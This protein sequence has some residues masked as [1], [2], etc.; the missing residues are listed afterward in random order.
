MSLA[1]ALLADFSDEEERSPSPA[2]E[3][4]S[5]S[6][7]APPDLSFP[8]SGTNKRP[9]S[10]MDLDTVGE[11][12]GINKG[13]EGDG[14]EGEGDG[15]GLTLEDGTSA[16]GYVPEGGVKPA[17]EL[18]VEDVERTDMMGFEDV[19][20]V[21]KLAGSRKLQ[22][23]IK[24]IAR[25]T[26]SPTDM[27]T[28]SGPLEE[29]PEY[30][31]VV[32][33]NNMSVEVDNEI[34]IVHKFIRD[35]YAPRFPE[36]EQLIA[37]PW[38]YIAA[39][40]AIGQNEDVTKVDFSKTLLPAT[41]LSITLTATTSRG[42]MLSGAEYET[43]QRAI[44][45]AQDLR[46]AREKIFNFVESR[47]AAVA[48]N[49][50]ILVGTGIAAKLLGLAGGLAAISRQPS[51]NVMLFGAMKKNLATS[52]LSAASQQR[53]TG[54]IFQSA[55]V[56]S[57]QPE[58]RRRAQR[59]VAAKVV[60]A[61]RIDA[62]KGSRDGSFGKTTLAQLQKKIE[63]MA[64]PP[65]NKLI[66]ALPIPQETNRKKRGG[67]RARKQKEAYAQTELRKLQNRMEF[68][69]AEEEIGVDD[70]TVGLGMIGSAGKV[71]G[72][73]ADS[74]SKAKLSRANKL[75][76][77]LLGRSQAS[78][79]AASGMSTSLSFTPVQ[80]L[81]IVTPSLSAAQRVKAAN[82]RWFAGGTFTHVKKD[83]SNL[84]GQ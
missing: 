62:G 19:G 73:M 32:T 22:D 64:E 3:Q 61:A 7:A 74:R 56:Q 35:H 65:P 49:L 25:F 29:N 28:A 31:L 10:A 76:T 51:C 84:P 46:D 52:H 66:K 41:M 1:D 13:G 63:K 78:N 83:Q 6:S 55:I 24:D 48:P 57:A 50:S 23:V 72:E 70:E 69:K 59:A 8:G 81:E 12:D 36:L 44:T 47:M 16:V 15:D 60:L 14:G 40:N 5:S 77:Q 75:R 33:A 38:T 21:A 68:G 82:D 71:R 45:V 34:L 39:V 20:K 53:H 4:S 2:P 43:V 11:E 26:E 42:R 17:E 37:E 9:A 54:F 67:K 27:S 58:D 80:G 30:H 18:D 79:D